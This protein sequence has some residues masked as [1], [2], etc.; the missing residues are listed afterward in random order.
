MGE[1]INVIYNF[2]VHT[3]VLHFHGAVDLLAITGSKYFCNDGGFMSTVSVS[4][5][6]QSYEHLGS[7]DR[8]L[9]DIEHSEKEAAYYEQ[10]FLFLK[11]ILLR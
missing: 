11:M 7:W 6:V 4:P 10:C 2:C 8:L 1:N 5:L 3:S 9:E